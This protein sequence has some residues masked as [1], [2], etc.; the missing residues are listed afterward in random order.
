[1]LP[2]LRCSTYVSTNS[3]KIYMFRPTR[4][5]MAM[6]LDRLDSN[7][8]CF[9]R[10]DQ[11]KKFIRQCLTQASCVST[12]ST[13]IG[14]ALTDLTERKCVRHS[15]TQKGCFDRLHR[16]K[17]MF[18][19]VRPKCAMFRPTRIKENCVRLCSSQESYVSTKG[20]KENC[21]RP[22][23]AM[24]RPTRPK[25]ICVQLCSTQECY[26]STESTK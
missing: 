7:W 13:Q 1:M 23:S 10:I 21:V 12:E 6:F 24:F 9:D 25:E 18:D 3:T 26:G 19:C 4:I 17:N 15:L 8:L 16:S 14:Y 22:K 5:K 2:A 20:T 11:K